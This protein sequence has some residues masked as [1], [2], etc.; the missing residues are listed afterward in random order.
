MLRA[1]K[2][3]FINTA[4]GERKKKNLKHQ[5]TEILNPSLRKLGMPVRDE[6][7]RTC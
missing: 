6:G 3:P 2:E 5:D 7:T 1:A 4:L